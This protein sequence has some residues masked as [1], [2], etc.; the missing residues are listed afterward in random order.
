[1]TKIIGIP[2]KNTFHHVPAHRTPASLRC[3][4]YTRVS[5]LAGGARRNLA[6]DRCVGKWQNH[7]AAH[8]GGF[9]A[10]NGGQCNHRRHGFVRTAGQPR[11]PFP[12]AAHRAGVAKA[13]PAAH[14]HRNRKPVAGA[15]SGGPA[16]RPQAHG[17]GAANAGN[18]CPA[19][20]PPAPTQPGAGAARGHC[21]RR[22]QPPPTAACRRTHVQP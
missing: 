2:T 16:A 10:A 5:R 15:V 14:A 17:G 19:T 13:A 3:A 12:W 18:D 1:M 21:P 4:K 6:A 8:S 22:A 20:R 11:R 9:A 7:A